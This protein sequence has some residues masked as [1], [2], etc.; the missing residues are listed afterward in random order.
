MRAG[1]ALI[2]AK[3]ANELRTAQAVA[4]P[5]L[6]GLTVSQTARAVGRSAAWVSRGRRRF[7]DELER[8]I[9]KPRGGRRNELVSEAEEFA[10]IMEACVRKAEADDLWRTASGVPIKEARR[11]VATRVQDELERR[12]RRP[13]ALS[14][15]YGLL[16]RAARRNFSDGSVAD[17]EDIAILL[18]RF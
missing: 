7:I 10:L 16:N 5:L 8:P 9:G 6:L 13:V 4:L 2:R 3:T 15:V 14:T 18:R 1:R 11:S 17:W 12:L